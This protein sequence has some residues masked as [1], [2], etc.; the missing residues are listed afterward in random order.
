MSCLLIR[1]SFKTAYFRPYLDRKQGLIQEVFDDATPAHD[2]DDLFTT[3][4]DIFYLLQLLI[5][6]VLLIVHDT[7]NSVN[8]ANHGNCGARGGGS[9]A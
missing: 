1:K 9:L 2:H 6:G 7:P 4:A 3:R 8:M 5:P